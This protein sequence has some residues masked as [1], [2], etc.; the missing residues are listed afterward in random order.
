[1]DNQEKKFVAMMLESAK[2]SGKIEPESK[3]D[4]SEVE[5]LTDSIRRRLQKGE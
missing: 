1:M 5:R 3:I 2:K 4:V